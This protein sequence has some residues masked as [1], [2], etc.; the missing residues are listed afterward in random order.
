VVERLTTRQLNRATLARQLLLERVERSAEQVLED[1]VGLQSQAPLAPYVGLWTRITD[2][3]ADELSALMIERGAVRAG[4]MRATIHLVTA[5]DYL[6]LWPVVKA[7]SER[8]LWTGSPFGRRVPHEIVDELLAVVRSHLDEQP[9]TRTDLRRLLGPRW[10]AVDADSLTY[11]ALYLLPVVQ[12][13]PRGVWGQTKA[14][15]WADAESWIGAPLSTRTAPD[16]LIVRYLGAFGPA[17]V[18]DAQVWS[19]LTR[20][21]EVADRLGSRVRRFRDEAGRI[22]LDRPD[23]PRPAAD[24]PAPVRF[25]PEY[26]NLLLSHADRS[27]V[28]PD[29]RVVPLWPGN[30]AT[31]GTLLVDGFWR[32]NWGI[33][34]ERGR[35][36]LD[37]E[38]SQP[39]SRRDRAAVS[40]EG[41]RLLAFAATSSEGGDI[42]IAVP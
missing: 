7:V 16:D 5:T 42:R 36:H 39:L 30:G 3:R 23:A 37:I 17:S 4:L 40:T 33:V 6:A 20:L 8:A 38:A 34:P 31:R 1:L 21:S 29:E 32:G 18:Q 22:L 14:P 41:Q 24:T 11:A 35:A 25:L 28:V 13:T 10:P 9:R 2:F 15:T 19:G 12:V 27:R 26:D